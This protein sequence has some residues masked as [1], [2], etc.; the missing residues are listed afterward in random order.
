[1]N[2]TKGAGGK[3]SLLWSAPPEWSLEFENHSTGLIEGV[4]D[5]IHMHM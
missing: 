5:E 4:R 2:I 3:K 1:M